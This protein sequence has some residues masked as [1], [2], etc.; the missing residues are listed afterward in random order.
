MDGIVGEAGSSKKNLLPTNKAWRSL[1][2]H[3]HYLVAQ[4]YAKRQNTNGRCEREENFNLVSVDLR[5]TLRIDQA[6]LY[7]AETMGGVFTIS[8]TGQAAGTEL[9][10]AFRA[11]TIRTSNRGFSSIVVQIRRQLPSMLFE[12]ECGRRR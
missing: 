7:E 11:E 10:G 2:L 3:S 1:A 5:Q 9:A 8:A 12:G 6:A 4:V